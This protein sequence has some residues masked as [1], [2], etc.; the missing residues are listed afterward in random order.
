M[1]KEDFKV[2]LMI[3]VLVIGLFVA[4]YVTS[5]WSQRANETRMQSNTH[6]AEVEPV[7]V[8][9]MIIPA[10]FAPEGMNLN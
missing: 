2:W 7:Q 6:I 5:A 1:M 10:D 3:I 4:M 8:D 9:G